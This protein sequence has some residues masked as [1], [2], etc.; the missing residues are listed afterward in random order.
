[1]FAMF[2]LF[3]FLICLI[4]LNFNY[5]PL[6]IYRL[7]VTP[8]WILTI[9]FF[10]GFYFISNFVIEFSDNLIFNIGDKDNINIGENATVNINDSKLNVSVNHMNRVA[11]A[12][13]A[14]GGASAGIQMA[15]YVAGPPAIKVAAGVAT[16]TLVQAT[17]YTMSYFLDSNSSNNNLN[18]LTSVFAYL[19]NSDNNNNIDN[20][21]NI[22]NTYPL[23][24]LP[25]ANIILIVA[26]V[27]I[28]IIINIYIGKFIIKLNY[29]KYLPNNKLGKTLDFMLT[30][31][32]KLWSKSS[33]Y[34]LGFCYFMLSF[35]IIELKF[36]FYMILNYYNTNN[37]NH[38]LENYPL[39][40]LFGI[41]DFLIYSIGF[42]FVILILYVSKYLNL[43]NKSGNYLLGFCYIILLLC[44]IVCKINLHII[45]S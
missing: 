19:N 17:T 16:A 39:N 21:N 23:G 10:I 12:I 20:L 4:R 24:I 13:S 29:S 42:L 44:I 11:A 15:K 2:F 28:Y 30:R 14:A 6:L 40:L 41:N 38:I 9:I 36:I 25:Q 34:L 32:I 35:A 33:N 31:Y 7:I 26:L 1:M 22:L 3:S 45:L 5:G 37:T 18:R 27:F 43:W 8:N